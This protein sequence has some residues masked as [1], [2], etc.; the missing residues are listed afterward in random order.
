MP[1][2]TKIAARKKRFETTRVMRIQEL[3]KQWAVPTQNIFSSVNWGYDDSVEVPQNTTY[4]T[5]DPAGK[6]NNQK[7]DYGP[8]IGYPAGTYSP[9]PLPKPMQPA[10]ADSL[11]Q[12][13][14]KRL[15][16]ST[17]ASFKKGGVLKKAQYGDI[18]PIRRNS[19][20]SSDLENVPVNPY[21]TT[22]PAISRFFKDQVA[23]GMVPNDASLGGPDPYSNQYLMG[24]ASGELRQDDYKPLGTAPSDA[25]SSA[26]AG[27]ST[28]IDPGALITG[29]NTA[30]NN[31]YDRS[32]GIKEF[33]RLKRK[34][35]QGP[36]YNDHQ[37]G[38]GSQAIYKHGGSVKPIS[39]NPYSSPILEF[40]G[41]SHAAGGIPVNYEGKQVEVEGTETAYQDGTGDLNIFGDLTLPGTNIKFKAAAKKLAAAERKAGKKMDKAIGLIADGDPTDKFDRLRMDTGNLQALAAAGDLQALT[42]L[43]ER[44]TLL[45]EQELAAA[46][47]DPDNPIAQDGK[48]IPRP[49]IADRHNNPGNIKF[50]SWLKKYGAV[51]GEAAGDGGNFARFPSKENGIRAMKALLKSGPYSSRNVAD[52]VKRWTGGSGYKNMEL[53]GLESKKVGSLSGPE[54][55]QVMNA[56]TSGEDSKLYD[57]DFLF[58]PPPKDPVVDSAIHP[59][60]MPVSGSP[61]TPGTYTNNPPGSPPMPGRTPTP[62]PDLPGLRVPGTPRTGMDNPLGFSQIAPEILALGERP[63]F[64]PGQRYEPN[65]YQPYQV[66]FQDRLNENQAGFNRIAM[67]AGNNPAALSVLAGQKYMADSGVLADEFR[68][69]QGI[70]N[71]ITNKNIALLND[72]QLKNL[73]LADTQF[74][75]QEQAKANTRT[76]I[77]NAVSSIAAKIDQNRLESRSYNAASG[78]FPQYTFDGQGNLEYIPNTDQYFAGPS[79]SSADDDSFYTR[80]RSEY[81]GSGTLKKRMVNTPSQAEQAKLDYQIWNNRLKQQAGAFDYLK[82]RM[83]FNRAG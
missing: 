72:A 41:P 9:A 48:K 73:G 83:G 13:L 19:K 56:I 6:V 3:A 57:L 54:L 38:T 23:S 53:G 70:T 7:I 4:Y 31:L 35:L 21:S 77:N 60:R 5:F 69:N 81:N 61:D 75:R 44:L 28:R 51:K 14:L 65:L 49:S 8:V 25:R 62:I 40:N 63:D 43:K 66:S 24:P 36:G 55:K 58:T 52:A 47:D 22:D 78:L 64:V 18:L 11:S 17:T 80:S 15:G 20:I 34:Q 12:V 82:R 46:G 42:M 76:N 45:Q 79:G 71:D 30:I 59:P 33:S 74:V 67:Q 29:V 50:V 16:A 10:A 37:Y 26:G 32:R 1:D 39:S 2:Y 68:T 27:F